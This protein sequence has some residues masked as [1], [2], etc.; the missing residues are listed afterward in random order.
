MSGSNLAPL[1]RRR[2]GA[3]PEI[4][5]K[6]EPFQQQRNQT[7]QNSFRVPE[8]KSRSPV[9]VPV[10]KR[11]IK[12][13]IWGPL[14]MKIIIPGMP[15]MLPAN[16]TEEQVDAYILTL[17]I[18]EIS[19]SLKI[20]DFVPPKNE[21]EPSPEPL[22]GSRLT[23]EERYKAEL[24]EERLQ[25]IDL[26]TRKLPTF[27]PPTEFKSRNRLQEKLYIPANDFPE[28]NFIGLLIGPRGN[29]LRKLE[30]ESTVKISIRGKGSVKEGKQNST[31]GEDEDLHCLIMADSEDKIQHAITM[32]NDII[33]TATSLPDGH[34]ELKKLQLRELA[35]LNGTLRDDEGQV[36]TNCGE[37][38][39]RKFECLAGRNITNTLICRICG[40]A[41]HFARDCLQRNDVGAVEAA[42]KRDVIMDKE[43]ATLMAELGGNENVTVSCLFTI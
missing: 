12:R 7:S 8:Q 4:S 27:K 23:R 39:H 1:G 22:G 38:G 29:T 34:N 28:I 16:L 9:R 13:G 17:R 35:S 15:T 30:T 41:G 3:A 18:E 37:V 36:C 20:G 21:R 10:K 43:Y 33:E 6:N 31:P 40:G 2:P 26:G 5:T 42:K 14:K 32:I 19:R 24:E 25:L 11:V